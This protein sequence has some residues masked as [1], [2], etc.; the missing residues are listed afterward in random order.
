MTTATQKPPAQ[1]ESNHDEK[2]LQQINKEVTQDVLNKIKIFQDSGDL[3]L[4]KDYSAENAIRA[5]QLILVDHKDKPLE[6]CTRASVANALL[7][8]VVWGLSPLKKQVDF[9]KYGNRLEA[10]PSYSGNVLL[11]KRYGGLKEITAQAIFKGDTFEF[12]IDPETG[13]KKILKHTQTLE[14]ISS[15]E[16]IGAYAV[17]IMEDGS[18]S[19]EVMSISQISDAWNMGAT[20]GASPAHKNFPDEMAKKTVINRACKNLIRESSDSP[21]FSSDETAEDRLLEEPQDIKDGEYIAFEEDKD[22]Q[23]IQ[24]AEPQ[25]E[26]CPFS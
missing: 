20:K 7:K 11:A 9:I 4:P 19:C 2:L 3:R 13:R 10:S 17:K 6:S 8:M 21:L 22:H 26:D 1:P 18:T 14:G 15:K 24:G 23:P 5:A 16:I 25:K 12:I